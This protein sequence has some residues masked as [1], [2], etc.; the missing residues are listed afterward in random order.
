MTEK[1]FKKWHTKKEY[2][3]KEKIRPFFHEREVWFCAFGINIGFEQDGSG[4]EFLRPVIIIK[5]FNNEVFWGLPLTKNQK[6]NKYYFQFCI[7][8]Q[9][10]SSTAILSQIRLVDAKRLQYKVGDASEDNF[11]KI[12]KRLA[13]FLL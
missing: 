11:S 8:G 1:D 13:E 5:K 12:K 6:N 10:E 2:L 7:E 9:K 3:H 4:A